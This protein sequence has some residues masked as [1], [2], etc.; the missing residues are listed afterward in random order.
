MSYE[1]AKKKWTHGEHI[2]VSSC[3]GDEIQI[4]SS[5]GRDTEA[6]NEFKEACKSFCRKNI[7]SN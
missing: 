4:P 7:K 2:D 3:L 5:Y 1:R 6:L